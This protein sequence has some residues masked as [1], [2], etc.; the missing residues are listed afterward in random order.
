MIQPIRLGHRLFATALLAQAFLGASS[1]PCGAAGKSVL[2]IVGPGK[3]YEKPSAAALDAR[4]G[5]TV[6]I[7]PGIYDDCA[8]W[9][10]SDLLIE[11]LGQ[12]V[13]IGNRACAGK[14]VFVMSG[15]NV[16]VRNVTLTG[17][18]VADRN[19]AGIRAE[20]GNLTVES[21]RFIDNEEGILAA[22]RDGEVV[23][24]NSYFQGN[25]NCIAQCAHGIYVS[26]ARRL[27]IEHSEFQ[28]QHVGHHIKSRALVTEVVEN[29]VHDGPHGDASYLIDIPNGGRIT[30]EG[31][32]LEKG[33]SARN[34]AAIAIGAE[35]KKP[36]HDTDQILVQ[37]NDFVNDTGATAIFVRNYTQTP[38]LLM[39]NQMHGRVIGLEGPGTIRG[40]RP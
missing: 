28:E 14:G 3:H 35:Q 29:V 16:T 23:I 17:A 7:L 38:A 30:I 31:N 40:G 24:K 13:V 22:V 4:S 25:G 2:L 11:G 1:W 32:R 12:G 37:N 15:E 9:R 6:Q 26:S 10:Q 27:R 18:H 21:T 8:I 5:D 34:L 20:G 19:G 39:S 33:P 36:Q